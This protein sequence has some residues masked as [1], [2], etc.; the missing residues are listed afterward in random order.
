MRYTIDE[1]GDLIIELIDVVEEEEEEATTET[2]VAMEVDAAPQNESSAE[3]QD[4]IPP[5]PEVLRKI[6]VLVSS[7]VLRFASAVFRAMLLPYRFSEGFAFALSSKEGKISH[8]SLPEDDP[9]TMIE[10]CSLMH[11]QIPPQLYAPNFD[12]LSESAI[13]VDK[14]ELTELV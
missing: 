12:Q 5:K 10:L 2:P 7:K 1:E 13:T 11:H 6:D 8:L 4:E 14:G 9:Q 3:Q